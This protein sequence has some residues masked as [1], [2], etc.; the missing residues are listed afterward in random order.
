L[1]IGLYEPI[2]IGIGADAKDASFLKKLLAGT[3]SG[4]IGSLACNP[5]DV[6]KTRMMTHE[7]HA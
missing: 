3:I 6:M 1:R 5:L 7:G 4:V 2:K